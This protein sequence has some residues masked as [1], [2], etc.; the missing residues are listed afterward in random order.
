[1]NP[2]GGGHPSTQPVATRGSRSGTVF[3]TGGTGLIGAAVARALIAAGHTVVGLARSAAAGETLRRAGVTPLPG[4]LA[5]TDVLH[6]ATGT[7]DAVVHT[8]FTATDPD[9]IEAA[10]ALEQAAI[11]VMLAATVPR[12][13]RVIYTSGIGVLG[14]SGGALLDEDSPIDTPTGMVWRA[15][16]EQQ[17]RH[18]G[19]IVL[20]PGL[21]YGHGGNPILHT[22]IRVARERG[23]ASY[24]GDGNSHW[25]N[26]HVDDLAHAYVL[27]LA[28]A[29][30]GAVFNIVGA[31]ATPRTVMGAI[32]RLIGNPTSTGPLP[33]AQARHVLPFT[34]WITTDLRASSQRA[35]TLLGWQ[36]RGPNL[37]D[38]LATGSYQPGSGAGSADAPLN[39]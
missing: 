6:R 8:A 22:L 2:A 17:V 31:E 7:C 39:G 3:L 19:G 27:A 33:P 10:V 12:K 13:A 38:E 34:D 24:L 5:D 32:G 29:E 14:D 21:V 15:E 37:L 9:G 1:M 23:A 30:P 20:R 35:R 16:L 11:P 26:V 4:D 18:A 25:P 28:H 36:P